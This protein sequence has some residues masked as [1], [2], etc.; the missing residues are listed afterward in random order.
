MRRRFALAS[1]TLP[2]DIRAS[3]VHSPGAEREGWKRSFFKVKLSTRLRSWRTAGCGKVA[4]S[5]K[6]SW[7]GPHFLR[8]QGEQSR[9]AGLGAA[10]A[11][12]FNFLLMKER[13]LN[14][15]A[16]TPQPQTESRGCT[17]GILFVHFYFKASLSSILEQRR[18]GQ[19][20][21]EG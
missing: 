18:A 1:Q 10:A 11:A 9:R 15:L 19:G 3:A 21:R 16:A 20:S 14:T 12:R 13:L 7:Q 8:E 4:L 17:L 6:G 5:C 2:G